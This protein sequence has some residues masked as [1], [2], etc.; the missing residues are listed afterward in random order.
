MLMDVTMVEASFRTSSCFPR[1]HRVRVC[2][3]YA[4]SSANR[5]TTHFIA[6]LQCKAQGPT[7]GS[8]ISAVP[9]PEGSRPFTFFEEFSGLLFFGPAFR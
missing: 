2:A 3:Q 6:W 4:A 8:D 7:F 5:I 9:D 1:C